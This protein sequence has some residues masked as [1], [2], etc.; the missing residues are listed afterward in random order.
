MD[1]TAMDR[2]VGRYHMG[3]PDN[4]ILKNKLLSL[5]CADI[6]T[7]FI[8]THFSHFGGLSHDALSE[9]AAAYGFVTAY[10]GFDLLI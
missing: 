8:V 9:R 5:G 7:E 3:L 4:A 1:C 10:D 2:L 6:D